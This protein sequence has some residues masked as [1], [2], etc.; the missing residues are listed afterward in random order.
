MN[1]YVQFASPC[2]FQDWYRALAWKTAQLTLHT[3]LRHNN[4]VSLSLLFT[5]VNEVRNFALVFS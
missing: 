5:L 4:F 1:R 3:H 2:S